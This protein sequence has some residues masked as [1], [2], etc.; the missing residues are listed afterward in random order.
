MCQNSARIF[1]SGT[2]L[3]HY[4]MCIGIS[5]IGDVSIK[6]TLS[7]SEYILYYILL[8]YLSMD[9]CIQEWWH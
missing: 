6:L 4:G 9:H 2:V 7:S 1:D 5:P 3:A 8:I